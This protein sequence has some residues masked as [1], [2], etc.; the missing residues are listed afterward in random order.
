LLKKGFAARI[1]VSTL[2]GKIL[3]ANG[4]FVLLARY[5]KAPSF[6]RAAIPK[7]RVGVRISRITVRVRVRIG[8]MVKVMVSDRDAVMVTVTDRDGV[9]VRVRVRVSSAILNICQTFGVEARNL[10][11]YHTAFL[12]SFFWSFNA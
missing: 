12:R 2:C 6:R 1:S 9:R 8:D 10:I 5:F 3:I 7:V 11:L 4:Y